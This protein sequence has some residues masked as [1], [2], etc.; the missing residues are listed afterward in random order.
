M[1]WQP[2]ESAP[3][4]TL[5]LVKLGTKSSGDMGY[6]FAKKDKAGVWRDQKFQRA[7]GDGFI[8]TGWQYLPPLN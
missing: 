1:T 5:L 3:A 8:I 2:V 7:E 6:D 4:E